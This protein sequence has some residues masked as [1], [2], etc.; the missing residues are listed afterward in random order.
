[1]ILDILEMSAHGNKVLKIL[2]TDEMTHEVIF[3]TELKTVT[4]ECHWNF[5][6]LTN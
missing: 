5:H 1:M 3:I 6:I 2:M 4:L